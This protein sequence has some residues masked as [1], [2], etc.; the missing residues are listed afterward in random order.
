M[1]ATT[2]A[3]AGMAL[4]V[5]LFS[6]AAAFAVDLTFTGE[7]TYR[8]RIA[9]PP[10]AQLRVT[11]V[12]LPGAAPVAGAAAPVATSAQVPLYFTLNVRSDMV[13]RGG[14]FGLIAEIQADGRVLFRSPQ[15]VPVDVAAPVPTNI[16]VRQ[17]PNPPLMPEAD[18]LAEVPPDMLGTEWTVTSIGGDP[19]LSNSAITLS[20]AADRRSSGQAGCNSY[21]AEASFEGGAIAF[22]PVASTRK[23]CPPNIMAQEARYFTALAAISSYQMS[24]NGLRLTDAAGIPLIGLVRA[25]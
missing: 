21:F 15:P 6:A 2:I 11:L 1:F 16:L 22:G 4:V 9:L 17:L 7:V 13:A 20:F 18:L 19:V 8:E 25:P 3:R 12:T 5:L 14:A 23:A 24:T 10:D